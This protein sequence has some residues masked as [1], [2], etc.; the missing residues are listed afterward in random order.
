[1]RREGKRGLWGVGDKE[2]GGLSDGSRDFPFKMA[3][4]GPLGVREAGR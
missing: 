3:C 2:G 1:M 4:A